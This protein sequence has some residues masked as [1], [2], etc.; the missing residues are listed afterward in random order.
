MSEFV[1]KSFLFNDVPEEEFDHLEEKLLEQQP[2]KYIMGFEFP[3]GGYP[4]YH[5]YAVFETE[6]GYNNYVKHVRNKYNLRGKAIGG[7]RKQYGAVTMIETHERSKSYALKEGNFRTYNYTD[8]EIKEIVKRSESKEQKKN[9]IYNCINYI[10][11]FIDDGHAH[12]YNDHTHH[13]S[14]H[15]TS[16][17][18]ESSNERKIKSIIIHYLII[19]GLKPYCKSQINNLYHEYKIHEMRNHDDYDIDNHQFISKNV[20]QLYS[21]IYNI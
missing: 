2:L 17:D 15:K 16:Y 3:N 9:F 8:I 7:L 10:N 1:I 4:H 13:D 19:K 21:Q 14:Y 18:T 12:F 11:C 6:K 5:I 20:K